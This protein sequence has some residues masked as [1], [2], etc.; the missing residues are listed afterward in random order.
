MLSREDGALAENNSPLYINQCV[1][2]CPRGTA[3]NEF[4]VLKLV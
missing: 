4:K 1:S 2:I 3:T